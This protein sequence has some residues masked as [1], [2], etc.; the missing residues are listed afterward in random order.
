MLKLLTHCMLCRHWLLVLVVIPLFAHAQSNLAISGGLKPPISNQFEHLSVDDGLSSNY[1]TS[2]LQDRE[3]YM[4]FGTGDGLNK[5]DG[6]SFTVFKPDPKQPNRSFQNG[7]ITG[8]CE[9]D[10]DRIWAVTDG[11][12]LHE[13]NRKT[14]KVTPHLIQADRASRWNTQLAVYQDRKHILWVGTHI[15]LARYDPARRHFLLYPSPVPDASIKAVFEDRQNRFWVASHQGLYLF[16][17]SSGKFTRVDVEGAK[18]L[19]PS[20]QAFY[21]DPNDILWLGSATEG[22]SLYKLNLRSQPCRLMPYNPGGKLNPFV[23]RN[24]LH[25]DSTGII[26]VGTTQGLQAV[27]PVTDRVYTYRSDPAVFEG[28]ASSSAQAVYHDRSG[29]LWVGTDNGIDRQAAPNK[30][31]TTYQVKPNERM[32]SVPENRAFAV[33]KDSRGQLWFNNSPTLCRLSADQQRLDRIS[34]DHLIAQ[35]PYANEVTSFLSGGTDGIWMG[36]LYGLHYYNQATGKFTGYP[37]RIPAQYSSV[38]YKNERPIGDIWVGGNGG[39]ASFN[40]HT[41]QYTYYDVQPNNPNS[42]PDKDVYGVLVSRTG[43]VWLLIH[44]LGV[45]RLNPK[46]GEMT[47][48]S[49]GA[50]GQLSSNDVRCIHEDKNGTIW[51]GTHRGGLN[52]FDTKTGLFS[53]ITHQD[54]IPG[55]T[56]LGITEDASG[57]LWLSTN[58]GLCRVDP[59][60]KSIHSYGISDGLPSNHFKH[61]AVYRDG[62]QLIFGTDN[63]IVQFNPGQISDV[64]RPFPVYITGLM[65]MNKPWI[66]TDTL[67]RLKHDENMLTINFAALAYEQPSQ[68]QYAYQLVGINQDWVDNGKRTVATYN[69]LPPGTYTFR[70]KAANSSGYWSPNLA[71]IQ[72][73]VLPPWWATWWAYILYFLT[74]SGAVWSYVRFSTIRIQQRQELDL[75]RRQA[76]QL[77][78]VDELKTRF[79]SNITHE[80]RTPLTLILSPTEQ[81]LEEP[82][83]PDDQYRLTLIGRNAEKLLRLINQ[84]LDLTKLEGNY[85]AVTAMQG[86]VGEFVDQI[87][88]GFQRAAEQK[89]I[90]L[91]CIINDLPIEEHVFDADKWEKILTNL[92]ANALKFTEPH[93]NVT[94]KVAPV[95]ATEDMTSVHFQLIDSGIG[96]APEQVPHIFDRFFQAD[97]SSTRAHE[98]TGIGLAMVHELVQLLKGQIEVKSQVNV[99]TTFDLWLPVGSVSTTVDLPLVKEF[100]PKTLDGRLPFSVSAPKTIP[101]QN[102]ATRLLVVED[103]TEL[104]EFL[105]A[106]LAT[107]YDILQAVDGQEGWEIAQAEL[108]DI[109]L[110]DVMMP[111]MDGNELCQLIKGHADTDHIAVVMLSAKTA[112]PSRMQSLQYGAD[113]YLSKPFSIPELKLRL[114]NLTS[115]QQKLADH[116]RHLFMLPDRSNDSS[117]SSTGFPKPTD[118]TTHPFLV[119]IHALLDQHLD[120]STIG[121]DWLANQLAMSRRTLNRKIQS[122]IQLAPADLIRQYRIRKAVEFLQ[123]GHNVAETA[124]RVGFSTPSHFTM[125]FKEIYQQTPSEFISNQGKKGL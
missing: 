102:A 103:N 17:R 20:F 85:M 82:R 112:Q 116:Y 24:T 92:L 23:W 6:A 7:Y 3:G 33:F 61:N 88:G 58:E 54:G 45:C 115:R 97:T 120:D 26:W 71:S 37:C 46:T 109:I 73:L 86:Q 117:V 87:V 63:G 51:I 14:G 19:Q 53:A 34:S 60:T 55:N 43:E 83:S 101:E 9:G 91:T 59:Q 124:D 38:Q 41:R 10:S 96:I 15:G 68:N 36:S 22:Y 47:R 30:F 93:G 39:F 40:I 21:L 1:V 94:L 48:H 99:G 114:Q 95:W 12:G 123:R 32:A 50:R 56:V 4:W 79:F 89:F 111:R 72:L 16:D 121:V 84:L 49:A 81:M 122:L 118:E 29:M 18:G 90:T 57:Q 80:F 44:R 27:D 78:A 104:R 28:L 67:I 77:K 13:V 98:G 113:E 74:I 108:P 62:D 52:R 31:F 100:Q 76:E 42:I 125:V 70:V 64:R 66:L 11:G 25:R 119:R 69:S 5:Y 65:V 105:V 75:N 2:I 35:K 110:T 106:E 8:L 107:S